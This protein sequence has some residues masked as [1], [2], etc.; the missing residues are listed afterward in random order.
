MALFIVFIAFIWGGSMGVTLLMTKSRLAPGDAS[1]GD[2]LLVRFVAL[3]AVSI[4][5]LTL[6]LV[7]GRTI[8]A[9]DTTRLVPYLW[10]AAVLP[11]FIPSLKSTGISLLSSEK[12]IYTSVLL[13]AAGGFILAMATL[14]SLIM[15]NRE[16]V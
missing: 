11:L 16:F 10:G 6:G 9:D 13:S 2:Q 4:A 7:S 12:L 5:M 15:N 3:I 1:L 8:A 14:V